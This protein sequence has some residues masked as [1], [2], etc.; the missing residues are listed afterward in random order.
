[1]VH[2]RMGDDDVPHSLALLTAQGQ[3]NAASVNR[4]TFVDQKTGQTLFGS[5][6]AVAVKGAG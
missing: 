6:V 3:R 5:C 4:D 2:V 1:M